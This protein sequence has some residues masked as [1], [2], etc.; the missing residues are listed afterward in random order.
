MKRNR[1]T[2]I[3]TI[4]KVV[5]RIPRPLVASVLIVVALLVLAS[6][7]IVQGRRNQGFGPYVVR[8]QGFTYRVLFYEGSQVATLSDG[9]QALRKGSD[10]A[11]GVKPVTLPLVT[12]CTEIGRGWQLAFNAKVAGNTVPICAY[13][14]G[15]ATVLSSGGE[16]Y[17]MTVSYKQKRGEAVHDELK[18]VFQSVQVMPSER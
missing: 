7:V 2:V 1:K 9:T 11:V 6:L 15:Y 3:P 10:A 17:L 5:S 18:R 13:E 14:N 16:H 12:D 8:A 4:V